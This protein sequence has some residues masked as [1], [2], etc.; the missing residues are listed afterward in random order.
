MISGEDAAR[1]YVADRCDVQAM[2]RLDRMSDMLRL[3]NSQQNL[4]AHHT[5]SIIWSR[6]FADSAQLLDHV[7]R[8]TPLW[9]DLG[10]GA[11]FP[12]LVISA[13]RPHWPVTLVESRALRVSW[14]GHVVTELNLANCRI[15]GRRLEDVPAEPFDVIS[16]RAFA[17]LAKLLKLARR[18]S[19]DDTRWLLP[20]GRSAAQEVASLPRDLQTAFHVEQSATD[21]DSGIVV[22]QFS[23]GQ[24]S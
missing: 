23:S 15:I 1:A 7:S 5:L 9:L 21:P 14:L 17:P 11:G 19:T 8:E 13:M 12:G 18:F 22:G 20:K 2:A 4:V 16:A 3:E 6:H 24:S 10:T